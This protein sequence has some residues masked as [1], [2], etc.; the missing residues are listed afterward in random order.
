MNTIHESA[1]VAESN[2]AQAKRCLA[3]IGYIAARAAISENP[4]HVGYA[5]QELSQVLLERTGTER[6]C[7]ED[8]IGG[9]EVFQEELDWVDCS[10]QSMAASR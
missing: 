6:I 10:S 3:L 4:D 7:F 9:L 2:L 8:Q 5:L 1:N